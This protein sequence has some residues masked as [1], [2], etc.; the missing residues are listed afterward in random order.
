[1]ASA[2][3]A[4]RTGKPWLS[5]EPSF[6]TV[7][8]LLLSPSYF[9]SANAQVTYFSPQGGSPTYF[10]R[11]KNGNDPRES[12]NYERNSPNTNL[13]GTNDQSYVR[14][15][16]ATPDTPY[17]NSARVPT[18]GAYGQNVVY[19]VPNVVPA[20]G[21]TYVTDERYRQPNNYYDNR[22]DPRRR[23]D[24][25][26]RPNDRR[27]PQ[28]P[29]NTSA[30]TSRNQYS[31]RGCNCSPEGSVADE[32]DYRGQC[33]CR[34]HVV[35]RACDRCEDNFIALGTTPTRGECRECDPCYRLLQPEIEKMRRRLAEIR[36]KIDA[37]GGGGGS[38][39]TDKNFEDALREVTAFVEKLYQASLQTSNP[40]SGALAKFRDFQNMLREIRRKV[41]EIVNRRIALGDQKDTAERNNADS[42]AT[43]ERIEDLIRQLDELIRRR[44]REALDAARR[45]EQEFGRQSQEMTSMAE[46]SRRL[47]EQHEQEANGVK[48]TADEALKTSRDALQLAREA[49]A[50]QEE[51]SRSLTQIQRG[52]SSIQYELDEAR[53]N[54]EELHRRMKECR[55]EARKVYDQ[56][57]RGGG[58]PSVSVDDI[59]RRSR[60]VQK[61]AQSLIQVGE[62]LK[63]QYGP[64][65]ESINDKLRTTQQIYEEA[66]RLQQLLDDL[67]EEATSAYNIAVEAK[68]KADGIIAEALETLRVLRN[69]DD[70]VQ[71]S[72][73]LADEALQQMGEIERIIVEA[74]TK[75]RTANGALVGSGQKAERA[76]N[77]ADEAL[78]IA[79][80]ANDGAMT[81]LPDMRELGAKAVEERGR[82]EDLAKEVDDRDRQL[83][84]LENQADDNLRRA[85]DTE[86][87]AK[88]ADNAADTAIDKAEDVIGDLERL[89]A[90]L[91]QIGEVNP[92]F[93]GKLGDDL[94]DLE[95]ELRALNLDEQLSRLE[96]GAKQQQTLI[97]KYTL[98]L[99]QLEKDVANIQDIRDALPEGCYKNIKLEEHGLGGVG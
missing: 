20:G 77:D 12:R 17:D 87:I 63:K 53:R 40:S 52:F 1:M 23:Y 4:F 30:P 99:T 36:G 18:R 13:G 26:R 96:V 42:K 29:P 59:K 32:C 82:A 57:R 28:T 81:L 45:A 67:L 48:A 15:Q 27:R 39:I 55:D 22:Q 69:F 8:V 51:T 74:E 31:R 97:S 19:T 76:L 24:N 7:A 56:V 71:Q 91:A 61:T 5:L 89:L 75:T 98:D 16:Y 35:G 70:E 33:H 44:G 11:D 85:E 41:E 49:F 14:Y 68:A 60:N 3:P 47:A 83:E 64:L 92:G 37:G 46:E 66:V 88:E 58:A 10:Y 25:R 84:D 93:L 21:G 38:S 34:P 90:L 50:K 79:N 95:D 80:E 2:T 94:E 62:R 65:M 78:R 72:K 6:L 9:S 86:R 54:A 43:I 73:Q